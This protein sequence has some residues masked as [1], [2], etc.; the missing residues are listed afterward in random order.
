MEGES[1][2]NKKNFRSYIG[3]IVVFFVLFCCTIFGIYKSYCIKQ[4]F[5]QLKNDVNTMSLHRESTRQTE[6][7]QTIDYLENEYTNY[8]AF[9]ERQQDFLVKLL[10]LFGA[11]L[12]GVISFFEI[13]GRTDV[14]NLIREQYE[15]Q[16][17]REIAALIGGQEKINYLRKC[18]DKEMQAKSKKILF[19]LQRKKNEELM[20]VY[21]ILKD[22]DYH[23]EKK[24]IREELTDKEIDRWV[25]MYDIVVYQVD[26]R[27]Y[28]TNESD[29]DESVT[30]ARISKKCNSEK[31]YGILY[32]EG[33]LKRELY[34]SCFYINN[35]NYGLT[36]MERIFNLLY[37]V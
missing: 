10:G 32:C 29:L 26:E 14:S 17:E 31:V 23:I 34:A 37:L 3:I 7:T 25:K 28:G 22:Q 4:D 11:G 20:E 19:L 33:R 1:E 15:D 30:Y 8:R 9:V 27:E 21:T 18:V 16:V 13:K 12:L 35:A 5:E 2:M 24:K 6:Y 36:L